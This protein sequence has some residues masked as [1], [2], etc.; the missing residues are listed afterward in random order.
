VVELIFILIFVVVLVVPYLN[1]GILVLSLA[2][3]FA[4]ALPCA[5]ERESV[6]ESDVRLFY[7]PRHV[8]VSCVGGV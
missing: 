1:N 3:P 6:V 4:N 2:L 8:L 5:A 7:I